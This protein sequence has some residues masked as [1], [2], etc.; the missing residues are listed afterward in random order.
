MLSCT[1]EKLGATLR[2]LESAACAR[3]D[4]RQD[5]NIVYTLFADRF[6]GCMRKGTRLPLG[7]KLMEISANFNHALCAIPAYYPV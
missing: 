3:N 2:W 7:R 1:T 5:T 4:T 6:N